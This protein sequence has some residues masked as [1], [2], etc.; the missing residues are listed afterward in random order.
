M[1]ELGRQPGVLGGADGPLAPRGGQEA[2]PVHI[3]GLPGP[4][5]PQ[6][7]GRGRGRGG[8]GFPDRSRDGSGGGGLRRRGF[9]GG[10]EGGKVQDHRPVCLHRHRR[11]VV[12][13]GAPQPPDHR[14]VPGD[15]AEQPVR[16][17]PD[18]FQEVILHRLVGVEAAADRRLAPFGQPGQ[19][20]D[21]GAG[22]PPGPFPGG[23]LP[24]LPGAAQ[25]GGGHR[26]VH[27]QPALLPGQQGEKPLPQPFPPLAGGEKALPRKEVAVSRQPSQGLLGKEPPGAAAPLQLRDAGQGGLF[28]RGGGLLRGRSGGGGC[29]PLGTQQV[30]HQ[31]LQVPDA[32]A[33]DQVPPGIHLEPGQGLLGLGGGDALELQPLQQLPPG[34]GGM[35]HLPLR[36]PPVLLPAAA[37]LP[38]PPV[39]FLLLGEGVQD[40]EHHGAAAVHHPLEIRLGEE[41]GLAADVGFQVP[42]A[43][44]L[45]HRLEVAPA[46]GGGQP[47]VLE[48][49]G[50]AAFPLV[51][52]HEPGAVRPLLHVVE[53]QHL[54]AAGE[55]QEGEGGRPRLPVSPDGPDRPAEQL[56]NAPGAGFRQQQG[57]P[58]VV[59]QLRQRPA[60]GLQ[61]EFPHPPVQ[62][63]DILGGDQ[64]AEGFGR[65][66]FRFHHVRSSSYRCVLRTGY[67]L[68]LPPRRKKCAPGRR[69]RPFL[70]PVLLV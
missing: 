34:E 60:E 61:Q 41:A 57:P 46:L 59:V 4:A 15:D 14:A 33:Q 44:E 37:E 52:V 27:Q 12:K 36:P 22:L 17:R 39:P 54:A 63:H 7:A 31:G 9:L 2:F 64:V 6:A 65:L 5:Q 56:G 42:G 47:D 62:Q 53:Q 19:Q 51:D 8:G 70:P 58:G 29:G 69:G 55:I 30:H 48:E 50:V 10:G 3:K 11:G 43:V 32:P 67:T 68:F 25:E 35:A 49:A 24:L 45:P 23:V 18:Q 38:E 21:P 13:A 40:G 1:V 28:S 66:F 20:L 16:R 26:A